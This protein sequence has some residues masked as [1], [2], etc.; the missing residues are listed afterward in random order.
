MAAKV[1]RN[2]GHFFIN[3]ALLFSKRQIL[4]PYLKLLLQNHT[5]F[6]CSII[7][8]TSSTFSDSSMLYHFLSL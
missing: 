3:L 8:E 5:E 1:P 7:D 4:A 2:L 6:L